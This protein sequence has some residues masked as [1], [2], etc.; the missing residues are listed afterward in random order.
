MRVAGRAVPYREGDSG[1]RGAPP[2]LMNLDHPCFRQGRGSD[3]RWRSLDR[4]Y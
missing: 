1:E 2:V 3:W 4:G